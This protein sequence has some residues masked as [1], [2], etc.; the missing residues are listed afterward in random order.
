MLI[1]ACVNP[2]EDDTSLNHHPDIEEI[3]QLRNGIATGWHDTLICVASDPDG[4]M[5]TFGWN[6]FAG[7]LVTIND[8][9]VWYAPTFVAS[10]PFEIRVEDGKG[11]YDESTFLVQVYRDT[12]NLPDS[13]ITAPI[14]LNNPT[15]TILNT[16]EDFKSL[17]LTNH[18]D[19]DTNDVS[20]PS[21]E[22]D[23]DSLSVAIISYGYGYTSGCD[24]DIQFIDF[25]FL[26]RDTLFIQTTQQGWFDFNPGC[27]S[28]VEPRHWVLF[29]KVTLPW[30]YLR[31]DNDLY[32]AWP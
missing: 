4:D 1:V 18:P 9:A 6:A 15:L 14:R 24:E 17:W 5:L 13:S 16:E 23:F 2:Q 19:V 11:G 7:S 8:T 25:L 31:P 29:P 32:W 21:S 10:Y 22:I 27:F 12:V 20:V 3:I 28:E 26:S 30:K